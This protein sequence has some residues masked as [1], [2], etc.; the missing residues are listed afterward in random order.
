MEIEVGS[1]LIGKVASITKFGAFVTLPMGRTGMVHISEISRSYVN[2]VRDHLTEG[3]EVKVCVLAV[4]E[5]GRINLSIKKALPPLRPYASPA[6]PMSRPTGGGSGG[7]GGS[8]RALSFEDKLKQFMQDSQ[9]KMSDL[10]SGER[11]APRRGG[12]R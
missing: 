11:R 2:E 9:S 3:Q 6:S 4:D 5:I 7:S 12:R 10:N 1:I 8:G